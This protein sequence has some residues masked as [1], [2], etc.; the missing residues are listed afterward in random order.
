MVKW[1]ARCQDPEKG[2]DIAE[3]GTLTLTKPD[4]AYQVS[5]SIPFVYTPC[6][7]PTDQRVEICLFDAKTGKPVPWTVAAATFS[8][9]LQEGC[10]KYTGIVKVPGGSGISIRYHAPAG[11]HQVAMD[12]KQGMDCTLALFSL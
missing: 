12:H 7:S 1:E 3:D 6:L 2:I 11:A 8:E 10:I 9:I 5:Y 4:L